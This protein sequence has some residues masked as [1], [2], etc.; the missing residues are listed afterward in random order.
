M[1]YFENIQFPLKYICYPSLRD[2]KARKGSSSYSL[3]NTHFSKHQLP[4]IQDNTIHFY[5][6]IH[7]LR[8]TCLLI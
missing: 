8:F 1:C 7:L 5:R 4:Y 2:T 3:L 6:D